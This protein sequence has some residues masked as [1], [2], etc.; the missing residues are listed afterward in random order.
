MAEVLQKQFSGESS[1]VESLITEHFVCEGSRMDSGSGSA[2]SERVAGEAGRL[3]RRILTA[4]KH[5]E[6]RAGESLS[7]NGLNLTRA[8][9]LACIAACGER[10]CSQT[11]LAAALNLSESNICT[12]IERMRNDGWLFRLRSQ[13][14]RR[15]SVLV[16][17]PQGRETVSQIERLRSTDAVRW[18][19]KLSEPELS[20]L[21]QLLDRFL[22]SIADAEDS[23][24]RQQGAP[25]VLPLVDPQT[26]KRRAS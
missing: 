8:D 7:A 12:L 21:N 26:L 25:T 9:V 2:E 20:G 4:A 3:V 15:C 11:D 10:G 18:I 16:L 22:V 14:D 1:P 13:V 24:P 23:L 19:G 17:S 6:R 5:I